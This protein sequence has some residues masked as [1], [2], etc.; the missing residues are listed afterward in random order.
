MQLGS[1]KM[2]KKIF[3]IILAIYGIGAEALSLEESFI[4]AYE[5]NPKILA[6]RYNFEATVEKYPQ[7]F[8]GMLPKVQL[9]SNF[10][11]TKDRFP[12]GMKAT[13]DTWQETVSVNQ[14]IFSG[15]KTISSMKLAKL[16]ADMAALRL[17]AVEQ[18][19]FLSVV[20][21]YMQVLLNQALLKVSENSEKVLRKHYD[22]MKLRFKLGEVAKSD[23]S[24]TEA[25][26][27]GA[28]AQKIKFQGDLSSSEVA[29]ATITSLEAKGLHMI[30]LPA[31]L[32]KSMI[33]AENLA[34]IRNLDI[35]MAKL[36]KE[37][38]KYNINLA[39]SALLP[40]V[41]LS[42]Q[43]QKNKYVSYTNLYPDTTTVAMVNLTIPIYQGGGEYAR[44]REAKKLHHKAKK[45]EADIVNNIKQ[46]IAASWNEYKAN[47]SALVAS[48]EAVKA[49][50]IAFDSIRQEARLGMKSNLD[51]LDAEQDLFRSQVNLEQSRANS[52][53]AAYKLKLLLGGLN[54]DTL[55][56]P[57]KEYSAKQ[58]FKQN[59]F[60]ILGTW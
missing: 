52:I 53:I 58:Y 40:N 7:A 48:E 10:T 33:E 29:F 13:G 44:I 12:G 30:D 51:L 5:N 11:E 15:G 1:I 25:R 28:V 59:R 21:A 41:S 23:V 34:K 9:G 42:G 27:A 55:K 18:Q 49:S 16:E 22:S 54:S 56:L 43:W 3:S 38:Q 39:S 45:S 17:S 24:Q 60:K 32:P 19:V 47:A 35:Q 36:S 6:E 26:L 50:S 4:A 8:S 31:N 46:Q 37:A 2:F 14:E 57:V 20:S